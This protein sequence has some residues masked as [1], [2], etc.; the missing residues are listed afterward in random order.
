M[1]EI[2]GDII[3]SASIDNLPG[4]TCKVSLGTIF[5]SAGV[6]NEDLFD[7]LSPKYGQVHGGGR[8]YEE[9]STGGSSFLVGS[10]VSF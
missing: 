8:G 1:G 9:L 5:N 3:L 10:S 4:E 6:G 2:D 7:W